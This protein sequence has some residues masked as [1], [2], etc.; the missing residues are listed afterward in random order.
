MRI[1]TKISLNLGMTDD[2]FYSSVR[3][4]TKFALIDESEPSFLM[5]D[6]ISALRKDKKNSGKQINVILTEGQGKLK[7]C[8]IQISSILEEFRSELQLK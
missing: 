7:K 3:E 8:P 6:F 4:L 5:D 2:V 1:A